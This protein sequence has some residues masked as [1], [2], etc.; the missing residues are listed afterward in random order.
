MEQLTR[1]QR[2]YRANKEK[3]KPATVLIGRST[4][5]ISTAKQGNVYRGNDRNNRFMLKMRNV[6]AYTENGCV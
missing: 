1:H 3:V 5:K 4:G 2:Y 6:L